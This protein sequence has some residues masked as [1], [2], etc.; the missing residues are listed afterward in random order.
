MNKLSVAKRAQIL[1]LLVEGSSMRATSRIADVSINTVTKLLV[2]AGKACSA[3]QDKV[4]RD[5]PCKR[6]QVDEIWAFCYA[7]QKNLPAAKR[8]TLGFGDLWTWTAIC[9]DTKLV[10][11]WFIGGRD[12]DHAA[13]FLMDLK[14]RLANRVQL[15]SD[16]QSRLSRYSQRRIRRQSRLRHVI[17]LYG[18][19]SHS[20]EAARRYSPTECIGAKKEP[21]CGAPD[22]AHIS[23]SYS[24]RQKP[25]DAHGNAPL[26]SADKWLFKESREPCSRRL[27]TLHVL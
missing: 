19:P 23:T 10:P 26:Y 16:G 24:E 13:A 1:H 25:D 27:T 7:K 3:Y 2:D 17:K 20:P 18:E 22:P 4:L 6:I 21:Q 9:A 14:A 5:L 11:S 12:G 8:E 15:T